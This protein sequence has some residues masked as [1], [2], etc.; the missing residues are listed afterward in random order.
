MATMPVPKGFYVTSHFGPRWGTTHYGTDF[1][2]GGGS[3]GHPVYAVKDGT[4]LYAGT[5]SGFGQWVVLD[6]AANVGGGT[7]VNG[8]VI[9]EV[10]VGQFVREGQRI[11]RINPDSATNGGVAPHLHFEWHRYGYAQPGA[12]RLD[13]MKT[14]LVGAKWVGDS[15][16]SN[17][18]TKPE[19]NKVTTLFGVD[20]SNHQ[21][22]LSCRRVAAEG[23]KF[24][25]IKATEG[26]W[27]DPIFHSHLK[28][29]R[30][31][32]M[33]VGA[34]VYVRVDATPEAHAKAAA[35]HIGDPSVPIAL[36]IEHNSGSS[37]AHWKAIVAALE[38]RG[39]KVILTYLPRWYW[40]QVGSP[41]LSGLPPLW[42]SNYPSTKPG[43]ASSLYF[44]NGGDGGAG[45]AGYGGNRVKVWQFTDRANVAGWQIDANAFKGSENDLAALFNATDG[46]FLMALSDDEQRRLLANTD[47]IR[48]QLGPWPQLGRNEKGE[49]LTLVD[50]VAG[51]IRKVNYIFG[52]LR[53]WPQL[54]KN[55][56]GEDLTPVDAIAALRRDLVA[57]FK[58]LVN[59]E[60]V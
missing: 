46:G 49:P 13:P 42:S 33:H 60:D 48:G 26:T 41:D 25:M 36:D 52:Q 1:G 43:Y 58:K 16:P 28:D 31:T 14:V 27:K 51:L 2:N 12:D 39:Y 23:F 38:S 3:G 4:V 15:A 35:D 7:S 17:S 8:H 34:Y 30:S 21:N 56:A 10:A 57:G 44:G 24:C 11:A 6:H 32:D 29:A 55:S 5:A 47:W 22:G 18:G 19:S 53:P 50:A 54:G 20:I 45:W 37:V 9:P 40:L 59:R